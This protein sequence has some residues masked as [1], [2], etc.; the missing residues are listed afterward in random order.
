ML[1]DKRLT[2]ELAFLSALSA[3][4]QPEQAS[5]LAMALKPPASDLNADEPG[6]GSPSAVVALAGAAAAT[7]AEAQHVSVL[8]FFGDVTA[9]QVSTL[10]QEVP[11]PRGSQPVTE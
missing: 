2:N 5:K 10:R 8:S 11:L 3:K 6:G 1:Q 4:L 9:S 7:R